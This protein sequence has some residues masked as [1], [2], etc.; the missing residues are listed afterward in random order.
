MHD[1][2]MLLGGGIAGW[3]LLMLAFPHH[4]MPQPK[5][6]RTHVGPTFWGVYNGSPTE[7][8]EENRKL[9][10]IL[11]ETGKERSLRAVQLTHRAAAPACAADNA[12]VL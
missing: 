9:C 2:N 3:V 8:A 1:W 4:F 10:C 5:D 11:Q 12:L 7:D 6:K